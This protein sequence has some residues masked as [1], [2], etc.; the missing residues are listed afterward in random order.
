MAFIPIEEL[1]EGMENK[2]MAVLVAAKE[3]RRLNDK[4]R[5]GRMDMALKPISL[6]LERL[7]D[8]KVEFHGND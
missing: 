2:Y 4:R 3:A 8:H 7:R 6:A 1:S 5:M